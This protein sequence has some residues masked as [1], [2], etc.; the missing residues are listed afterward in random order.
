VADAG[1]SAEATSDL[2]DFWLGSWEVLSP[3]RERLGENDITAVLGGAALVERWRDA[4]GGEGMSLFYRAGG[5]WKQVW[6]TDAATH[7]EKVLIGR[8]AEGGVVFQGVVQRARGGQ[9]LDRTTL[10]PLAEGGVRQVIE[11]SVDGG[12]S[13]R[14]GFDASYVRREANR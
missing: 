2:L 13:W 4:G 10:T 6:V 5:V 1:P 3:A 14:V 9:Y 12:A 7:K 11:T 8:T